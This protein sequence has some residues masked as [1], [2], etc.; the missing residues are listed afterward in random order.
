MIKCAC[1]DLKCKTKIMF[2]FGTPMMFVES[3]EKTE[4][5]IYLDAATILEMIKQL[6]EGYIEAVKIEMRR[7]LGG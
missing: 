6:Q 2:D 7:E 1:G 3:E 4:V 5:G